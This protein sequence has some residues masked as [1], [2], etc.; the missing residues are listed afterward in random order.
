MSELPVSL[1]PGATRQLPENHKGTGDA[2]PGKARE[3][4]VEH[5]RQALGD[6]AAGQQPGQERD[7]GDKDS[8]AKPSPFSLFGARSDESA[9]LPDP[10]VL[11]SGMPGSRLTEAST[12][13]QTTVS[14]TLSPRETD[15]VAA[16]ADRILVS[17]DS[18]HEVR[19]S[20][21]NDLLP[22][23]EL[24]LGEHEGRW[25]IEFVVQDASSMALL[26]SAAAQMAKQLAKRL[27]RPVELRLCDPK[28]SPED[29]SSA[30]SFVAD[31]PASASDLFPPLSGLFR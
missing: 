8:E 18:E 22:G 5:F 31:E 3:E 12:E 17:T 21:R 7:R 1:N 29:S 20:I 25:C 16:V 24:H 10:S 28:L 2:S 26:Q 4:D 19:I 27:K 30:P 14:A 15:I 13:A 9:Q 23:V 6:K 11:L